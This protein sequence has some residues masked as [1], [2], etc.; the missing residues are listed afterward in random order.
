MKIPSD[1]Q[2]DDIGTVFEATIL[3]KGVV[4]PIGAATSIVFIFAKPTLKPPVEGDVTRLV[5]TAT[6]VTNGTD[7]KIKYTTI[8]GDLDRP[9]TWKVQAIV[10]LPTGNW[11]SK[12]REFTV[13]KNI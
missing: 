7:G 11:H 13:N 10:T 2:Q 5:K 8:A 6:F 12:V 9:G 4:L 1:I 3:D